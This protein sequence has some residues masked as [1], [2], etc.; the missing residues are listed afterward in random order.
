MAPVK[1]IPHKSGG[2][3]RYAPEKANDPAR[4]Q[5]ELEGGDD[6]ANA[7]ALQPVKEPQEDDFEGFGIEEESGNNGAQD[8][9]SD[10]ESIDIQTEKKQEKPVL[11]KDAEEEEL[12]RMIFGDSEGFRQGLE[13]FSLDPSAN[14]YGNASDESG[15]EEA[16][17]DTVADQDLFFFDAGPVPAPAGSV[18]AKAAE[19]DEE[20]GKPAWEDSD[21]ERLVVSLASVPK[22]RKLRETADDDM[23]N[24]KEYARRLR[25]QYQ[26]LYPTPDWAVHATGKA[27][28][29][30]RRTM[31][32]D[33]SGEE[34]ASDMDVDEEDLSTQ[35]LARLLKDADILSRTSRI[36]AKRRKLQAGTI[37]IQRLKDVAKAG[38]VSAATP[39]YTTLLLTVA[40]VCHYF[41]LF[42]SCVS[43]AP[44]LRS[45]LDA[46]PSPCQP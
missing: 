18:A 28:K 12:E 46:L 15:A 4:Y 14:A 19:S 31:D 11:P 33:E 23:V 29:K 32:D 13:N 22:L 40:L 5:S 41:P 8:E 38:P 25:K 7:G 27:N 10:A 3:Q 45:Q 39:F 9:D 24:G 42:P 44:I 35:P 21:D 34:S 16:D 1:T 30:R 17:L 26:R 6:D 43:T 36:V 37:D 20:D 2:H